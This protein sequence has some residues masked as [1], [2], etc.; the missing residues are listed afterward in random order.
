MDM[1]TPLLQM[2]NQAA[3]DAITLS[4]QELA[5]APEEHVEDI[6]E[7]LMLLGHLQAE[8]KA[9]YVRRRSTGERMAPYEML[10]GERRFRKL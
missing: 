1:S 4:K 10:S 5:A 6:E 8:L 7:Y 2:M 9:E 3:R